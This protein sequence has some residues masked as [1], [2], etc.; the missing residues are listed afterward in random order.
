[1]TPRLVPK[2]SYLLAVM[3]FGKECTYFSTKRRNITDDSGRNMNM[4]GNIY[5][6]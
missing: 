6:S 1:M 4:K 2:L 3:Y 5:G